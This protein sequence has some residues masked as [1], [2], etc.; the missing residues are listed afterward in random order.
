VGVLRTRSKPLHEC[1]R[2]NAGEE[3]DQ[4]LAVLEQL[5]RIRWGQ[6][7]PIP[8]RLKVA[9]NRVVSGSTFL[10]AAHVS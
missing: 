9:F 10:V 5:Q 4:S 8:L 3:S 6:L 7:A 1:K 2:R